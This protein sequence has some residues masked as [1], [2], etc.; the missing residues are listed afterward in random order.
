MIARKHHK[1]RAMVQRPPTQ[2]CV[3]NEV[4]MKTVVRQDHQ[5]WWSVISPDSRSVVEKMIGK[6]AP[7]MRSGSVGLSFRGFGASCRK[8][9]RGDEA[10]QL[11]AICNC[12]GACRFFACPDYMHPRTY[13]SR[14]TAKRRFRRDGYLACS[15][16][17][18]EL[19]SFD[20]LLMPGRQATSRPS[21]PL[22]GQA[23][24]QN[25]P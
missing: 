2:S 20:A 15:L 4:A 25:R 7:L 17:R 19:R 10:Q 3:R 11:R 9:K 16:Q 13:K 24:Q 14:H 8:L 22:Q 18:G 21:F 23:G 12:R 1:P 5:Q 6:L